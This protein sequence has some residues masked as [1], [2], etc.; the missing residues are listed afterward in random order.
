MSSTFVQD[1]P[2]NVDEIIELFD[3]DD[4]VVV[5]EPDEYEGVRRT[6]WV[7]KQYIFARCLLT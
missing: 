5:E 1:Q 6:R 7:A 3:E 4:E 2:E